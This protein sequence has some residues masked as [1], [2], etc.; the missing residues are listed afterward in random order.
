[1]AIVEALSARP[2]AVWG[3]VDR[4]IGRVGGAIARLIPNR[5][6]DRPAHPLALLDH[7]AAVRL[8]LDDG[9]LVARR[10]LGGG[11]GHTGNPSNTRGG[12][13][14]SSEE[15][16]GGTGGGRHGVTRWVRC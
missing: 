12:P 3:C 9:R 14:T 16:R 11:R 10:G 7:G 13:P 4:A 8:M 2:G 15:K 1:M 6:L 5:P